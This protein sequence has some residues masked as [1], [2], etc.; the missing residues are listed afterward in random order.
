[1][2]ELGAEEISV[3][4]AVEFFESSQKKNQGIDSFPERSR[5]NFGPKRKRSWF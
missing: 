5:Q 1:M 3:D 4:T 2:I